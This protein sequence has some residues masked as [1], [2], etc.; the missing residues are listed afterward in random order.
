[1]YLSWFWETESLKSRY[2]GNL[3]E[4]VQSW[5]AYTANI[6][7]YAATEIKPVYDSKERKTGQLD[8]LG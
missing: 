7:T 2:Q 6:K 3:E 5:R 1:M 4:N 8:S